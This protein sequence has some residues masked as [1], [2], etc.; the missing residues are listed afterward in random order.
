[1]STTDPIE[2]R[3]TKM[4]YSQ[5]DNESDDEDDY[6]DSKYPEMRAVAP[7]TALAV[8]NASFAPEES[9]APPLSP[10]PTP[11]PAKVPTPPP[12]APTVAK[13]ALVVAAASPPPTGKKSPAPIPPKKQVKNCPM[14][15]P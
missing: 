12:T 8:K 1:M 5:S 10:T 3:K 7:V 2:L 15:D 13:A 14:D 4:I 6:D 9:V 11:P